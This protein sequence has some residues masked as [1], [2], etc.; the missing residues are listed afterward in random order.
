M[1]IF[2]LPYQNITDVEPP[3]KKQKK[4]VVPEVIDDS[5]DDDQPLPPARKKAG[6]Q[7]VKALQS[8]GSDVE[9]V[10]GP[11]TGK[12]SKARKMSPITVKKEKV[13]VHVESSKA[14]G[15]QKRAATKDEESEGEET[16]RD[17]KKD[18]EDDSRSE[19][20]PTIQLTGRKAE[21][22]VQELAQYGC[23]QHCEYCRVNNLDCDV[24]LPSN[25]KFKI[26][27]N[28]II[29]LSCQECK[30]R[31]NKRRCIWF[32]LP[33]AILQEDAKFSMAAIRSVRQDN[34]PV[35]VVI[36]EKSTKI[37]NNLNE[38]QNLIYHIGA[39]AVAA[40]KRCLIK[41][42]AA[43]KTQ[44]DGKFSSAILNHILQTLNH[45]IE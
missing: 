28:G 29:D 10:S 9:I 6:K 42:K 12:A 7:G 15:K 21:E 8:E 25:L 34:E 13:A 11:S 36:A 17:N 23:P 40:L 3:K 35:K 31:R 41:L 33:A 43:Q 14:A 38:A 37:C 39:E 19:Q 18:K 26:G 22:R 1:N 16:G 24:R 32:R 45:H 20:R 44:H 2:E 5:N 4:F 30:L 27:N